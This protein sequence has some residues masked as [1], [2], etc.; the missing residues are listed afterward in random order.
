MKVEIL[1]YIKDEKG[2][3]QGF[4]DFKVTHDEDRWEIFRNAGHY[5]KDMRSWISI[6]A[7]LRN[8]QWLDRYERYPSVKDILSEAVKLLP[9]YLAEKGNTY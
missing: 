8:G 4:V 6:G 3:R 7:C 9:E 5:Q 1:D 2:S